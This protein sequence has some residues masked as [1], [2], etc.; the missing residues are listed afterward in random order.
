MRATLGYGDSAGVKRETIVRYRTRKNKSRA[1]GSSTLARNS[2][3]WMFVTVVNYCVRWWKAQNKNGDN[4][5]FSEIVGRKARIFGVTFS[6]RFSASP[7]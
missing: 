1:R 7:G 4:V 3:W 5:F 6:I 2:S